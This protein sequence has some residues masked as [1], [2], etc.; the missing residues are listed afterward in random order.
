M[1]QFKDKEWIDYLIDTEF[2]GSQGTSD[3]KMYFPDTE[4]SA[5]QYMGFAPFYYALSYS[6]MAK[7][8]VCIGSGGG[9]VPSLMR[10]AQLD[11]RY[12][13]N[14]GDETIIID[15][16]IEFI[17]PPEDTLAGWQGHPHWH[18]DKD[19]PFN[20]RYPD[21]KR[22]IKKSSEAVDDITFEID[23]LHIDGD[24]SYEGV[25]SDFENYF[26]KVK[27]NGII[28][29]HDTDCCDGIQKFLS[30]L[31]DNS[32]YH[33]SEYRCDFINFGNVNYSDWTQED[34]IFVTQRKGELPQDFN[35]TEKPVHNEKYKWGGLAVI[36]KNQ[37]DTRPQ[38][39]PRS[40][41][42]LIRSYLRERKKNG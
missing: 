7:K 8:C 5:K 23:F 12:P 40:I 28:T 25:K 3:T 42:R 18:R 26:P 4:V 6:L 29:V 13:E 33:S 31:K 35:P 37:W 9:F 14:Y 10:Q 38:S 16:N 34:N 2:S 15:A 24:H 11:I 39:L 1:N 21:I 17:D 36:R 41:W 22:I 30:E 32:Q 27:P 19:H 20:K